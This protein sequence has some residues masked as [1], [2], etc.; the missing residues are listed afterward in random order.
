MAMAPCHSGCTAHER[1][2]LAC[3][4][5][6]SCRVTARAAR[7][8]ASATLQ[9]R[10]CCAVALLRG[11]VP[12]TAE[13]PAATPCRLPGERH[14]G[15]PAHHPLRA[16]GRGTRAHSASRRA[17]RVPVPTGGQCQ[18]R[19]PRAPLRLPRRAGLHGR[20]R[21]RRRRDARAW[22]AVRGRHRRAGVRCRAASAMPRSRRARPRA[23]SG[24]CSPASR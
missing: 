19:L 15:R 17:L 7:R 14:S 12:H 1:L 9:R 23:G 11:R 2:L 21:E 3:T 5:H 10:G 8:M 22:R 20:L 13:R 16:R 6:H 24:R 18:R 4:P